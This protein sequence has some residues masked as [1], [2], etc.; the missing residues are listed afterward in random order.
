M[1]RKS[2]L[3]ENRRIISLE[4]VTGAV[5]TRCI[6]SISAFVGYSASATAAAET[7]LWPSP[8]RVSV[9]E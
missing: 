5:D 3:A 6:Y 2:S 4:F 1:A 8:P 7:A 9:C